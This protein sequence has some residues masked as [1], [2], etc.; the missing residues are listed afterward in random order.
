MN[1]LRTEIRTGLLVVLSLTA[2]VALLLYLGAPGVFV[3][4]K[5]FRIFFDNA[6]GLEPGAPVLLAGRKIGRVATLYSPVAEKDRPSPKMETL[7]EVQV[8]QSAKIFKKVKAQ[9][10]QPSILGKPVIDFTTGEEASGLADDG[11]YFIG[12][13][14][15]GLADAVPAVLEKIDPALSKV[16]TTLESLQKTAD[17]LTKITGEGSDLPAAFA[18]FKKFGTNLNELSGPESSLRRSLRNVEAM[19]SG[20]GQLGKALDHIAA[21]TGPDGDLAKTLAN[22]EKFTANLSNNKDIEITL[23]NF[24]HASETLDKQAGLLG[25]RFA[26][27]AANLEQASD[28]VKRQP[29]RLIWPSTKTYSPA[30][31]ASAPTPRPK[32]KAAR[33]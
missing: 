27:I 31:S 30:D 21:I 23:R 32:V 19:T 17:N 20:D 16:S 7:V 3:P 33:R 18:E 13:R 28:T 10:T 12:E 14:Q 8:A 6:A 11:A 5:K 29:W 1:V 22:A 2:L 9:M 15:P 24:R 26:G 25:T 4:Q